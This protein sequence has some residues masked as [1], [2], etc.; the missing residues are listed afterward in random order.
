LLAR[1]LASLVVVVSLASILAGPARAAP[2][3]QPVAD[4]DPYSDFNAMPAV[5]VAVIQDGVDANGQWQQTV[6]LTIHAGGSLSDASLV[7][8]GDAVHVDALFAA[9]QRKNPHLTSPAMIPAGQQ[10]DVTIDPSTV[11]AVATVL[12]SAN[13]VVLRFT[14]GV[15]STAYQRPE[16]SLQRVIAFPESK[17]TDLFI[18]PSATQPVKVRPGGRIV[19][20]VYAAGERYGDLVG[21]VCGITSFLA[22]SDLTAQTG[23]DPARWP[24]PAG[25][26]KRVVTKPLTAYQEEPRAITPIPNPHPVGQARQR[27]QLQAR[28]KVG[29]FPVRLESFG[30]VYHV[31]LSDPKVTAGDVSTLLYGSPDHLLDVARAAG[32]SVPTVAAGHAAFDP[33][34]FG[35][36]FDLTVDYVDEQ[37][38]LWRR[39]AENGQL[40][41]GLVDGAVITAYPA[42]SSGPLQVVQYPTGYKRVVYRPP[43]LLST[44]AQGLALFHAA[45][46]PSLSAAEAN[47]LAR[48]FTAEMLWQWGPGVPRVSGDVADTLRL[49]D[50]PDGLLLVA[51]VAPPAPRSIVSGIVDFLALRNPLVVT[52]AVVLVGCAVVL[53]IDLTRRTLQRV[54]RVR[55]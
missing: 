23:W 6:R 39:Y 38:V 7:M 8:Y 2:G 21:Q 29:I 33:H 48:K 46:A 13:S 50:T 37:F 16:G 32:F 5:D 10:I 35:R 4:D 18:Y 54:Q 28:H 30:T 36:A 27:D 26:A 42:A 55:W 22:A 43:K 51:L 12:R 19:D 24:P 34:L 3:A 40:A 14:N 17:P 52:G 41:T 20:V 11:F 47:A 31:A 9:A 15:V 49:V 53:A 45:N 1:L 25:A 44:A